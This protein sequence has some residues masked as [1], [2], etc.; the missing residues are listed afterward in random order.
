MTEVK[1]KGSDGNMGRLKE[2]F[3]LAGITILLMV[4]G[5]ALTMR[6]ALFDIP[7]QAVLFLCI[8][9]G[10]GSVVG[11]WLAELL[12]K[13]G[14]AV[15]HT[16]R[17]KVTTYQ[18]VDVADFV[19]CMTKD[20]GLHTSVTKSGGKY[21]KVIVKLEGLHWEQGMWRASVGGT[22][23]RLLGYDCPVLRKQSV[24][25]LAVRCRCC[26]FEAVGGGYIVDLREVDKATVVSCVE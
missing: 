25:T 19:E 17:Y 13:L 15:L 8:V 12:A 23:V 18:F 11:S 1:L 26:N 5:L 3:L 2:S 21:S 6:G 24:Y 7:W 22:R 20:L 14:A 9:V 10:V 4:L 16:L